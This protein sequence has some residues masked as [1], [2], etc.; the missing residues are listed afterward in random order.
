MTRPR[1][2]IGPNNGIPRSPF[3]YDCTDTYDTPQDIATTA[4]TSTRE[5][6]GFYGP[7]YTFIGIDKN[8]I[9][10]LQLTEEDTFT[11]VKRRALAILRSLY[12]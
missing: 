11:E 12:W 2:T 3:E 8:I 4:P 6:L 10:Q 1:P 5:Y 9:D 7:D